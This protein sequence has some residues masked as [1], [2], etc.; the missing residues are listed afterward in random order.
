MNK[1]IAIA[2]FAA[3]LS[4]AAS[5][6]AQNPVGDFTVER[7]QTLAGV[8]SP[9]TPVVPDAV[10]AG[11]QNGVIEFHQRFVYSSA[12]RT[13]EQF[14]WIAPANSP[15]P[16]TDT[17]SATLVD[18]YLVQIE[19]SGVASLPAPSVILS[20]HAVSNDP[21]TPFG[22]ITG[23]GVTLTFGYR[24]AGAARHRECHCGNGLRRRGSV[25]RQ[26]GARQ[27][28]ADG[29]A[30]QRIGR[31]RHA[32]ALPAGADPLQRHLHR[33]GLGSGE[34]GPRGLIVRRPG[35]GVPGVCGIPGELRIRSEA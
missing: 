32:I 8:I 24:G 31:E 21:P 26:S 29:L 6:Q 13:L 19:S 18:H 1:S 5:L 2:T 20:G 35:A 4:G 9:N 17:T 10:L 23:A 15:L 25:Q 34:A 33:A 12:N 7:V 28:G 22:N 30:R 16:L 3:L 14:F 11:V 27:L